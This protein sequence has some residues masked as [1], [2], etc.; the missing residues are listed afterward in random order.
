M[1]TSAENVGSYFYGQLNQS[2]II[3]VPLQHTN[4]PSNDLCYYVNPHFGTR[5]RKIKKIIRDCFLWVKLLKYY[6]SKR[7]DIHL[8][9]SKQRSQEYLMLKSVLKG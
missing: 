7:F 2:L 4:V 9:S 6:V 1:E 8:R 3:K 5:L